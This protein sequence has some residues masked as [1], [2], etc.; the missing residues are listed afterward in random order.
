[1]G[2]IV[3]STGRIADLVVLF[4][5]SFSGPPERI[6]ETKAERTMIGGNFEHRRWEIPEK[7]GRKSY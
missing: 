1:M 6:L 5:D 7:N 3:L 2:R 4:G